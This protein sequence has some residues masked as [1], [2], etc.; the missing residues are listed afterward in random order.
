[1]E[2]GDQ[3]NAGR[4]LEGV[5]K[6]LIDYLKGEAST[7]TVAS[8]SSYAKSELGRWGIGKALAASVPP[9]ISLKSRS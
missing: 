3:E 7:F 2:Q 8:T 6:D 9:V 5:Y 1:M 4:F